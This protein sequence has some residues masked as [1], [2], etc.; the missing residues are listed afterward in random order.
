MSVVNTLDAT[1]Y[2]GIS[3]SKTTTSSSNNAYLD[4][5]TFLSLLVTQLENQNPLEPMNDRDFFA[6]MAQLGQVQGMETL[7]TSFDETK[8]ANMIGKVVTAYRPMTDTSSGTLESV[9]GLATEYIVKDGEVYLGIEE[10][11]GDTVEVELSQVKNVSPYYDLSTMTSAIGKTV[12][13]V[14][15]TT[16]SGVQTVTQVTGMV[17]SVYFNNGVPTLKVKDDQGTIHNIRYD[18]L[19][20]ITS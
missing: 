2:F 14:E 15:T 5:E 10:A 1:S 7:N 20:N 16:V 9:T 3:D 12:T 19:S 17:S 8:A 4:M 18:S 13:G 6:Q 11:D